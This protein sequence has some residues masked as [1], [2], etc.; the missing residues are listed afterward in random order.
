[1]SDEIRVGDLVMVVRWPH[2]HSAKNSHAGV[3]GT[4]TELR[5]YTFCFLCGGDRWVEPCASLGH[6]FIPTAC[7]KRIPPLTE[8]ETVKAR[9]GVPLETTR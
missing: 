7:L 6:G 2:K 5:D 9:R 8:P 4:V 3:V 1:M